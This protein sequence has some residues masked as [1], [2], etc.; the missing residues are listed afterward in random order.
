MIPCS[1]VVLVLGHES[2]VHVPLVDGVIGD[3]DVHMPIFPLLETP[4]FVWL[5]VPTIACGDQLKSFGLCICPD[6]SYYRKYNH[7]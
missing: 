3:L 6:L 4:I 2:V 7:S 5:K 1:D